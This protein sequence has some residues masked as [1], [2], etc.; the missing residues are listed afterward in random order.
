[1]I[2]TLFAF[3]V[4]ATVLL[5]ANGRV[6]A[7]VVPEFPFP[8]LPQNQE[9]LLKKAFELMQKRLQDPNNPNEVLKELEKI[10]AQQ[11]Q[12][13]QRMLDQV[14]QRGGKQAG[15]LQWGGVRLEKP[16][17][18]MVANLGLGEKEGLVVT[19]VNPGSAG[20]KAGLKANDVLIKIAGKSVPNDSFDFTKLVSDQKVN[21]GADLVVVRNGKEETLKGASMPTLVQ[22]KG[23]VGG[24]QFGGGGIQI[25]GGGKIIPRPINPRLGVIQNLHLEMTLNGAKIVRDQKG[26]QFSGEYTKDDVKITVNGTLD[27]GLSKVKEITVTEGKDTKKFTKLTEV[28]V[29]HR[30]AVQSLMPSAANNRLMIPFERLLPNLPD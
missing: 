22:S 13:L 14:N 2:R 5:G 25:G 23:T 28:P 8:Q 10:Q 7:Q 21:E 18:D 11:L 26:D 16:A 17:A 3:V 30:S 15:G 6:R 27:N 20:E 29:Q 1:M 12:E 4:G 24:I 9:E 19:S